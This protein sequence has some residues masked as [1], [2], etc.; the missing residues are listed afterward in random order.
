MEIDDAILVFHDWD[1]RSASVVS[2]RY[3][4]QFAA[5][6]YMKAIVISPVSSPDDI[7]AAL[8]KLVTD[9]RQEARWHGGGEYEPSTGNRKI[10]G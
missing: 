4:H 1:R 8:R 9:V 5:I 7:G 10:L 3:P 6:A 2:S